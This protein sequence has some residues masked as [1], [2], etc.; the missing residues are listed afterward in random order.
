[1]NVLH[2]IPVNAALSSGAALWKKLGMGVV[3]AFTLKGIVTGSML[4]IML[5]EFIR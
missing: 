5:L 1:M 3:L 2:V 4:A